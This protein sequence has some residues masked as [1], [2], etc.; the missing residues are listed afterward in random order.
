MTSN[1]SPTKSP[2]DAPCA[3][4]ITDTESRADQADIWM[5]NGEPAGGS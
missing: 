4:A 5:Q 2:W 3:T 1:D